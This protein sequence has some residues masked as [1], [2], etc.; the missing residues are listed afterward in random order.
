[1]IKNKELGGMSKQEREAKLS[2]LSRELIKQNAQVATGTV[3]KNPRMI[4]NI[5]KTIAKIKT[6]QN[7]QK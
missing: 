3:P 7:Q 2:E 4:R 5:K 1:M 6:I